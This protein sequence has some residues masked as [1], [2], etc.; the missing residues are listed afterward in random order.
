[1]SSRLMSGSDGV[2]QAENGHDREDFRAGF[3][4]DQYAVG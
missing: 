1:M 3:V 2:P 4:A